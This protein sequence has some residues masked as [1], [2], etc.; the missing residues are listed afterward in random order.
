MKGGPDLSALAVPGAQIAV[1]A[2][3]RARRPGVEVAGDL[4]TVRVTE[5]PEDG[6]ATEAVRKALARALGIA[7]SRLTLV[8]GAA[9]RSKVFRV[10]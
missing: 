1:R 7:P 3:P 6:R 8:R 10:E 9:S 4:V 2:V 5:P